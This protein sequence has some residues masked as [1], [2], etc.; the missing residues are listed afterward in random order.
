MVSWLRI[1]RL[2]E[3]EGIQ[4]APTANV[5]SVGS[6]CCVISGHF[7]IIPV[8]KKFPERK[9]DVGETRDGHYTPFSIRRQ[10]LLANFDNVFHTSR[11][12][13]LSLFMHSSNPRRLLARKILR[14][15]KKAFPDAGCSLR[16]RSSL[17]LLVATILSAQ[18]TDVQVNKITPALFERFPTAR[19]YAKAP[20][21]QIE[22]SIKSTG[23]YHNKAK[24]IQ[25]SCRM[26]LERFGG[27]VPNTMEALTSLPG[28]GRKTANVVLGNWFG[29]AEGITV[30]THVFRLS[31]R[32]GLAGG[33]T[34]EKVEKDLVELF[35]K[36]E[37]TILSH[38]LILHGRACC[39]A[40]K[41]DCKHCRLSDCCPQIGVR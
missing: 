20:L 29:L 24:N 31:R 40:Q 16:F 7:A 22:E 34:P 25:G 4:I 17:E 30:D 6:G 5:R 23:F 36:K 13:S 19:D 26:L 32:M 9:P 21:E 33:S 27:E 10:E 12:L 35:P 3:K 28:V 38:A 14:R 2:F 15:L 11:E 18:C 8:A 37:W 39:R 41:P 1:K